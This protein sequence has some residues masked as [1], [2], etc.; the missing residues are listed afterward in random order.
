MLRES[1]SP[2]SDATTTNGVS[3]SLVWSKTTNGARYRFADLAV[4]PVGAA[5]GIS[6][7]YVLYLNNGPRWVYVGESRD[8]GERLAEHF[9]D[10]RL[11]AFNGNDALMIT[12]AAVA[13]LHRQGVVCYLAGTLAPMIACPHSA[14]RPVTVNLPI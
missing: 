10:P 8:I 13:S 11:Q 7:V 12:W 5:R 14:A 1:K 4:E 9:A 3:L 2:S 6:G